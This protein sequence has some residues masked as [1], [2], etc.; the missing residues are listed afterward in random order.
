MN[1]IKTLFIV[2]LLLTCMYMPCI[3]AAGN[4]DGLRANDAQVNKTIGQVQAA[5]VRTGSAGM[6]MDADAQAIRRDSRNDLQGARETY[7]NNRTPENQQMLVGAAQDHLLQMLDLMIERLELLQEQVEFAENSILVPE[8]ASEN[9][10]RYIQRL[11]S[12]KPEVESADTAADLRSVARSINQEW[13]SIR[14]EILHYAKYMAAARTA[15][16]IDKAKYISDRLDAKITE[17][18]NEGVDTT[19]LRL[20]LEEFDAKIVCVEENYELA[21]AAV[22]DE[23]INSGEVQQYIRN[24]SRCIRE[25]NQ[26]LREMFK[27]LRALEG[28]RDGAV[29]LNGTGTLEASGSGTAWI[30]GSPDLSLSCDYGTL[31]V[32][33]RKGDMAITVTGNG[34]EDQSGRWTMYHGFDGTADITGSDV[35]VALVGSGI[36]LTVTG[37]GRAILVGDGT[38]HVTGSGG[39]AISS[40]DWQEPRDEYEIGIEAIVSEEGDYAGD[41]LADEAEDEPAANEAVN[42]SVDDPANESD[43]GT[44]GGGDGDADTS[45]NETESGT[46]DSGAAS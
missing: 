8:G 17:L 28:Y 3:A 15:A 34:V 18:G 14:K 38:Y 27:E 43:S 37:T 45:G 6:G 4:N 9:I 19:D 5:N 46:D 31:M 25:A 12:Y 1:K 24:A 36:D 42:E 22:S 7:R 32:H 2:S 35:S 41:D 11:E 30:H 44:D 13:S 39:E 10:D 29:I 16:Y 33:D 26:I 40:G 21:K 20:N 23:A